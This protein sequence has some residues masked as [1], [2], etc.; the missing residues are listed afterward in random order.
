MLGLMQDWP[1][2]CRRIIEHA[3]REHGDRRIVSRANDGSIEVTDYRRMHESALRISKR[4]RADGIKE[5]DRIGTVA[6]STARHA[7]CWYGIAG[8]GAVYHPINPRLFSEQIVHI[9]N[10][11]EDR[12]LFVDLSFVELLE[13]LAE[14]LNTVERYVLLTNSAAMPNTSLPNAISFD[15]WIAGTDE[16]IEWPILDENTAAAL[17][18]TSGTTGNPKGVLYSHRAITLMSLTGSSPDMYGFS[19][20]DNVLLV[21][22]MYHANGWTWPFSAPMT[23]ASL[24]FPGAHLDG[25]SLAELLVNENITISGGV[26]TVWQSIVEHLDATGTRLERLKRVYVGGS[27]CP[28]PLIDALSQAHGAEVRSSYG[29]T[30]MGPLGSIC[31]LREEERHLQGDALIKLMQTQ[32]RP[33]FLVEVRTVDDGGIVQPRDGKS[34]GH[35]SVRGPC[36]V[37]GYYRQPSGSSLDDDGYF[38]TGDIAVIDRAGYIHL[39]DRAKDLVKSGGE[40]ISSIDVEHA[41]MTH[42]DVHEAAVIAAKHVKW[43]ERPLLF[44]VRKPGSSLTKETLY[45]FL[46]GKMARWWLPDDILF[47]DEI[48][49]TATG[50]M[51]K[52]ILRQQYGDY[53]ITKNV[54]EQPMQQQGQAAGVDARQYLISAE[55]AAACI[56]NLPAES[57]P[58]HIDKVG[59]VGAGTMGRGIVMNFLSAG[60]PSVLIETSQQALD[61]AVALIRQTYEGS[62]AKGRITDVELQAN[63]ARLQGSLDDTLL[64][65]CDLVIE[66]VFESLEI[67]QAVCKKLGQICKPG[68]IIATNTSTLDVNLLAQSTGRAQDFVGMHFFSPAHIMK[69]LEVVRGDQTA[70]DVLQTVMQLA[71]KIN[72]VPVVSGVCYGFIGNRMLESYLREADF[73]LMEGA[74]PQ[75]IDRAIEARGLAMGPCRMLDMAGTDVAA[76]IVLEQE[77]AGTLPADKSYRAV[78]GKLFEAGRNGQKAKAGYYRY[79]GRTPIEDPAVNEIC[80]ALAKEHGITRREL[81]SDDEIFER[82]M[83]PLINGG[84]RILEEGISYRPSDID[85]VWTRGYGFSSELGGPMFMASG[86]GLKNIAERLAHYAEV[87]GNQHGYWAVSP[88]LA[89]LAQQSK[90][91]AEWCDVVAD[92]A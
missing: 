13:P 33:P 65:D 87:R 70:P 75:Q 67:K 69:L 85:V 10:D 14:K 49:H 16:D 81:I 48:P 74:T 5:G 3:A 36:I 92:A 80:I 60:I 61:N 7:E 51:H 34:L 72:K 40:W 31:T 23:G 55:K 42:P 83:Y 43:D 76:K 77:K 68:A 84:A 44:V 24:V 62:V 50:K 11:A 64:K 12:L 78:V 21:V 57:K 32:G 17:T 9:I 2:L 90:S 18:Y 47:I 38:A 29:M 41:V 35:L 58:R 86:M 8:L 27:P 89:A 15:D 59:V 39:A 53:L 19:A 6:W 73:L 56:P 71:V 1:L 25:A 54:K 37:S 79:E 46:E 88:L 26:P 45:G 4:L 82:C 20:S 91:F 30:E 63:M 66:A 22:P 28:R 52:V